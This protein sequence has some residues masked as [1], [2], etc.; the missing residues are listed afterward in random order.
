MRAGY[1]GCLVVM[2][3]RR[4]LIDAI[5]L[6]IGSIGTQT[7]F[8]RFILSSP[9]GGEFYTALAL[10]GWIAWV[11]LGAFI[12]PRLDKLNNKRLWAGLAAVKIPLALLIFAYPSFFTGILDPFRFLPLAFLGMAPLGI[13]YGLLFA[14]LI[15]PRLKASR[16]YRNEAIGCVI[17]GLLATVWVLGGGAD[18]G[19]LMI[20]SAL[21]LSRC[22][23]NSIGLAVTAAGIIFGIFAG[24]RMDILASQLRWSGFEIEKISIGPSGRW[25]LLS[26]EDQITVVHNGNQVTSIPDRASSEETLLWPFLY[27]PSAK[28]ILLI[29]YEGIPAEKYLPVGI[30]Y[31]NLYPDRA[32]T[33]LGISSESAFEISDPLRFSSGKRFGIVSLNLHGGADLFEYRKET[34]LFIERLKSFLKDD[35]VLFVSAPSDE[36][37]ISPS[38]GRYLTSLYNTLKASFDTVAVIPGA[39]AGFVC[40]NREL[41]RFEMNPD[42]SLAALGIESPY[43]NSPMIENRLLPYRVENFMKSLVNDGAIN[44]IAKPR[45]VFHFMKWQGTAFGRSGLFFDLYRYPW[46]LL[47]PILFVPIIISRLKSI[48][49]PAIFGVTLF[50]FTGM[51]LE[52]TSLYLFSTLFGSLYLH[53]GI[54]IALFMAGL[55]FGAAVIH[56]LNP[57][58][59]VA[60]NLIAVSALGILFGVMEPLLNLKVSL[61]VLYMISFC[62]GFATGGGYAEFANR[63]SNDVSEGATLYGADLYGALSAAVAVPGLLM[64]SGLGAVM[65]L[66][67]AVSLIIT[68]TLFG[69]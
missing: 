27:H 53:I 6:G 58:L 60:I 3:D 68:A 57:Y 8:L 39:K 62:G 64:I 66:I 16:V 40:G 21:E 28:D 15:N 69:R 26:R 44:K 56:R 32:F 22:F 49:I 41:I 65:I 48:S 5:F 13:L 37:Y 35:G 30:N 12:G 42:L 23:R 54:L 11:G 50:G 10:G 18:F 24:P 43:F 4:G 46:V 59:L 9:N 38:L 45:A 25:A 20:I 33:N 61:I 7:V 29:G 36:N 67:G 2:T 19:L 55:A 1:S 17:G 52:I 63:G 51:A 31:L 14:V 34:D 47:L